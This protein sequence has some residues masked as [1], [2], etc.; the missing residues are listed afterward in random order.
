MK[1]L[2]LPA[3]C[4]L[5]ALAPALAQTAP[6]TRSVASFHVVEVSNGIELR[7]AA[8]A[9]QLV[10][11]SADTPEQLARLKTEVR[12]GV[13]KIS[14]DRQPNENWGKKDYVRNLRVNVTAATP[15]TAL[16][17]SSGAKVEVAGAYA[18]DNLQLDLSSG[19]T[20]RA[21]F[22]ATALK[23]HVSSGGIAT[24]TGKIQYLDVHASSGGLFKGS[25]L[26]AAACDAEASSGGNVA[27]AVQQTLTAEASSGGGV[28]YSGSPQVTKH[29]SSGGRVSNR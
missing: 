3:L 28:R 10:D 6:E 13:L 24:V 26:Q 18:A 14:F 8:G 22:T 5:L 19:A 25:D 12:N 9:T 11:A 20:L 1:N 15:L 4:W 27:V 7:L 17:A 21:D 2:L 23:A 29:T 16:Q